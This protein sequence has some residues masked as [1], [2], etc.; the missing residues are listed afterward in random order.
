MKHAIVLGA[1]CLCCLGALGVKAATQQPAKQ[2]GGKLVF[3]NNGFAIAPLD[4]PG[5]GTNQALMMFLPA[6][7]GFAPNVNVQTQT[8]AGTLADYAALSAKQ[9]KDLKLDVVSSKTDKNVTMSEYSGGMQGRKLHWYTKAMLKEG[10]IYLVTA[11]ALEDQWK[12]AA[13]KLKACV[14]SF[15]LVRR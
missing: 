13:D 1:L 4:Q 10:T 7:D 12:G 9:I 11:T 5:K 6:A 15:D 3:P 8:Y 2:P 14:D